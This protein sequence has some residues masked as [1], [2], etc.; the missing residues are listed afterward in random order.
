MNQFFLRLFKSIMW[1]LA[2]LCIA[3]LLQ[4]TWNWQ[5]VTLV[6]LSGLVDQLLDIF[7]P[8]DRET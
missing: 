2:V 4:M 1:A 7:I 6:I 5:L 8:T 3:A